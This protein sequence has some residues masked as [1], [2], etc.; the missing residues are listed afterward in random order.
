M[1][2]TKKIILTVLLAIA[3]IIPTALPTFAAVPET[4]QP[5]WTSIFS[6]ELDMTFVEGDGNASGLA[7]KQSTATN[8]EGTITVYKQVG[9][10]WVFVGDSYAQ[11]AVGTLCISVDF[12]AEEGATY[13]MV[14]EV[15][16]YTGSA[17]ETETVE[18]I[19]TY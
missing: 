6:I 2:K 10:D 1:K 5:R 16:A 11:K 3:I 19:E 15:T 14:F 9:N 17:A 18:H 12:P 7:R 8:I 4:V 13:K